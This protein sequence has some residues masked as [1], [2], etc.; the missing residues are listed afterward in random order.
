MALPNLEKLLPRERLLLGV[1]CLAILLA[2]GNWLV[3]RRVQ[4]RLE[5]LSAKIRSDSIRLEQNYA[6][7]A[8]KDE[9]QVKYDGIKAYIPPPPGMKATDALSTEIEQMA[10][11]CG[12][13]L[14][15]RKPQESVRMGPFEKSCVRFEM[16]GDQDGFAKLLYRTETSPKLLRISKMDISKNPRAGLF[17]LKAV[18]FITAIAQVA[19]RP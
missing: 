3:V 18:I 8:K 2:L 11:R 6:I 7:I 12:V 14:L 10:G 4:T 5:E 15:D 13:S 9:V 17:P 1:G 19:E 16:M